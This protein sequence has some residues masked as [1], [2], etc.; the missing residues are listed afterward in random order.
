MIFAI[1][2]SLHFG[3]LNYWKLASF[4]LIH[5][6]TKRVNKKIE[7]NS[8]D[9]ILWKSLWVKDND[10]MEVLLVYKYIDQ[11]PFSNDNNHMDWI[12]W[13]QNGF[14]T[15]CL[16]TKITFISSLS[17]TY[18][19]GILFHWG[20][21]A[22]VTGRWTCPLCNDHFGGI[23]CRHEKNNGIIH[24]WPGCGFILL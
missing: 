15:M 8:H 5:W 22:N 17:L 20:D 12:L 23:Y 21:V 6:T 14:W 9:H 10:E 19:V 2:I 24:L 18:S 3:Y 4:A 16:N 7:M 13:L 11:K 1:D